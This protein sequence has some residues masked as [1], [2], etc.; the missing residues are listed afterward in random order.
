MQE[1]RHEAVR[2]L[3]TSRRFQYSLPPEVS[4]RTSPQDPVSDATSTIEGG[5][6]LGERQGHSEESAS[7]LRFRFG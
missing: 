2:S 5:A 7:G 1:A 4:G 3:G 6:R